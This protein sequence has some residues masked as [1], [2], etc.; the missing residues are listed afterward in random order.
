MVHAHGGY[1][2]LDT[3]C[4]VWWPESFCSGHDKDTPVMLFIESSIVCF[5]SPTT[6]FANS[7]VKSSKPA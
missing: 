6:S 2:Q 3:I 1:E 4:N 7:F 5:T